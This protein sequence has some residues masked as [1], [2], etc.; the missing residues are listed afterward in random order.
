MAESDV[1]RV[2]REYREQLARNED[3]ALKRMAKYW[4]GMEKRLTAEYQA[5]A[6]EVIDRMAR[7][8]AVPRQYIYTMERYRSMMEQIQKEMPDYQATTENLIKEYQRKDYILGIDGANEIIKASQPDADVWTKVYKDAAETMAGFAGN[9][10]PLSMLLQTDYGADS[11]RILDALVSGVGLGKGYKEVAKMMADAMTYDYDRAM[12]IARTEINRSYRLANAE[13]YRRSGVV[14]KVIRLCYKPTACFA[15]LMM[16]GEECPNGICDDHPNGKCTTIVQTTGGIVPE[17]EKGP[18]WFEKQD[19][20]DQRRIMGDGRFDLWKKGVPLR[21]MVTMKENPVWG[22]SPTMVT[23]ADL[24]NKFNIQSKPTIS[25]PSIVPPSAQTGSTPRD[26]A[27]QA[28]KNASWYKS[29]IR[30]SK[31]PDELTRTID[32]MTEEQAKVFA[33]GLNGVKKFDFSARS[34]FVRPW[35]KSV[36]VPLNNPAGK[37]RQKGYKTAIGT[38]F[39][40]LTHAVDLLNPD[41]IHTMAGLRDKIE[42]C[43]IN[44]SNKLLTNAGVPTLKNFSRLSEDQKRII[45]NELWTDGDGYHS[46]SDIFEGLTNDRISGLY[47]HGKS[48]WKDGPYRIEKEFIAHSG[49]A[50]ITGDR[51]TDVFGPAVK[52]VTDEMTRLYGQ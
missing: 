33:N 22:G 36:N 47:G 23:I 17:W 29:A 16:D 11:E 21:K 25:I 39:H 38:T 1:V 49:Q 41:T 10:A 27:I 51:F 34:G 24:K 43:A 52:M 37:D 26:T 31:A 15:C 2:A 19:E 14:E 12:R 30:I 6:Q 42:E 32:G 7:G 50:W 13:Q 9:G 8:E 48:Y 18:E 40:E 20:E 44:W 28:I 5:L 4:V 3:A 45:K 35:D 46:V